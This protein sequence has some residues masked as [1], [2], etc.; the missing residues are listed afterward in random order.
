M[1]RVVI[2][3]IIILAYGFV[4]AQDKKPQAAEEAITK[5][6][7]APETVILDADTVKKLQLA[8][9]EAENAR[10]IA[11]NTSLKIQILQAEFKKQNE[12]FERLRDESNAAFQR[13]AIKAGI[14]GGEVSQ[15]EGTVQQDGSLKLTRKPTPPKP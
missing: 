1:K 14:P 11:E 2:L 5:S 6:K 7:P 10:I 15:Y 13:A 3:L 12:V 4:S 9:K 8:A